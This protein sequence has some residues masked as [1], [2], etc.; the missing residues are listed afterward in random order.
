MKMYQVDAFTQQLFKGNPAAVL[1]L[2]EWLD[3]ALM[4]NIALENNL[5]ETAFVKRIDDENYQIRWFTPKVEVDFCGHATLA[6]AFVLFKDYT[7]A[8][9]IRFHVKDLGIFTIQQADD[10]KIQMN[11]PIRRPQKVTEYPEL[12]N[13]VIDK[14]F[15]EVYLNAQAYI[16]VCDSAQDVID[17]Q[18]NLVNITRIA[19]Q[20]SVSTALTASSGGFDVTITAAS[21]QY[22][23]VARYFAPHKGI[24]EDPVTG[25]MH[26]GL[27][28]LWA[29]KLAKN[30]LIGYQASERGGTLF[31]TLQADNRIEISGYAQLYMQAEIVI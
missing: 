29:E 21:D 4:Q 19:E 10:G 24:N 26:T 30:Q 1:V 11:F 20:Y 5:A 25:S 23:Y 7:S 18:A 9:T 15:K 6:S 17:A 22:D 12:L 13:H 31:C 14:P 3:H 8:K 2:D 28:P 16:L 27:A